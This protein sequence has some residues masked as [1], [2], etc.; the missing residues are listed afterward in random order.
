MDSAKPP[1]DSQAAEEAA[2]KRALQEAQSAQKTDYRIGGADLLDIT[3][4]QQTELNRKLRV[5]QNGTVI[6]PLI[7]NVQVGGRTLAE[8]QEAISGKLREFIINPQVT[9]FIQEYGNKKVFV[10]GEVK[11][12][13]SYELP[14]ESRLTVLEAISL[15]G[16]FTPIA[17]PDRTKVIRTLDGKNQNFTVEVSA[18]T[19]RG[20]KEKDIS[21]QPNDVIYVPQSFF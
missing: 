1:S 13:G 7:G 19:R 18:I 21:L 15:A 4:Y 2:V 9:V 12:P 11:A 8:A 3:V 5:S 14:T 6:F 16:G 10:L 20:E 17:S